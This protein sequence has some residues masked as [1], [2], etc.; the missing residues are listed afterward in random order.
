MIPLPDLLEN[1]LWWKILNYV[2]NWA[3][4]H[5]GKGHGQRISWSCMALS[6]LHI[7]P[8]TLVTLHSPPVGHPQTHTHLCRTQKKC[9]EIHSLPSHIKK[10][11]SAEA[12]TLLNPI[13]LSQCS[14]ILAHKMCHYVMQDDINASIFLWRSGMLFFH[15]LVFLSFP[16][17][18]MSI[19]G[20]LST[21]LLSIKKKNGGFPLWFWYQKNKNII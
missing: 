12:D 2:V 21:F 3:L 8:F 17:V 4:G 10:L 9:R 15:H 7:L 1:I 16:F 14:H 11:L 13:W 20:I 18:Y 19:A 5:L 6:L